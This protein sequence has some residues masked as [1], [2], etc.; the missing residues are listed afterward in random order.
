MKYCTLFAAFLALANFSFVTSSQAWA[1]GG[2]TFA[3]LDCEDE[4][5]EE[6]RTFDCDEEEGEEARAFDCEDEEGE[7]A[8]AV[9]DCHDDED[10]E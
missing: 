2:T 10:A 7:E 1:H 5:G 9:L 3:V 6:A 4:E 8:A